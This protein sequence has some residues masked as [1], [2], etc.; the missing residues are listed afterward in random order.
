METNH[1]PKVTAGFLSQTC[2]D[3]P[4]LWNLEEMI[5]PP[6][7]FIPQVFPWLTLS[8]SSFSWEFTSIE[9]PFPT[10]VPL[11]TLAFFF[12]SV[13]P[14]TCPCIYYLPHVFTHSELSLLGIGTLSILFIVITPASGTVPDTMQYTVK[15]RS[16]TNECPPGPWDPLQ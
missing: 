10:V 5:P 2:Q 12:G 7:T 1:F 9:K 8:L 16:V 4:C 3:E 13:G 15:S 11:I 6:E 14:L